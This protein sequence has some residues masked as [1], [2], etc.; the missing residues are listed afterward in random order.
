[1]KM[2]YY[3][4][5]SFDKQ[6]YL[7]AADEQRKKE[8]KKEEKEEEETTQ[9]VEMDDEFRTAAPRPVQVINF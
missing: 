2:T 1:M 7:D 9:T 8:Q 5:D 6:S 4:N 3:D